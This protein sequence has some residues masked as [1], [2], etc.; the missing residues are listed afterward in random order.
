MDTS[1]KI[2]ILRLI[3]NEEK[4]NNFAYLSINNNN[5]STV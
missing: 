3:R 5:K 1:P 4:S 2:T